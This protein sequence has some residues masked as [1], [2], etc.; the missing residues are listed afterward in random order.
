ML[1]CEF[2]EISKNIFLL[3]TPLV[4]ASAVT[5]KF[6]QINLRNSA[7][8]ILEKCPKKEFFLVCIFR[9]S[10]LFAFSPIAG[11]YRLEKTLYLGTFH[12]VKEKQRKRPTKH[13]ASYTMKR[14][15]SPFRKFSS[16]LTKTTK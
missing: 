3:R 15:I 2:C 16:D 4:V 6:I 12:P 10:Y 7:L 1:S 11:N 14:V 5:S 9:H 8:E 13:F